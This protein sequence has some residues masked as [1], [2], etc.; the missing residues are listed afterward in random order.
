MLN[1][2]FEIIEEL[3]KIVKK[4]FIIPILEKAL[5]DYEKVISL[6][7]ELDK[8]LPEEITEAKKI[9]KKKDEI[10]KEAQL[11]A[12]GIIRVAKERADYLLSENNITQKAQKEAE[13]ILQE[14]RK[15]AEEIKKEA[16]NYALLL[17]DK[18]EEALKKELEIIAKCKNEL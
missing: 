11:E 16:E 6:I 17:L 18:V 13:L 2:S 8:T 10:I 7:E 12:E 15:E 3:R 14:A 9:I 1:R 5:I 4:S